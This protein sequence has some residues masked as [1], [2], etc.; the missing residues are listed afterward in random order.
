MSFLDELAFGPGRDWRAWVRALLLLVL[1]IALVA[2]ILYLTVAGDFAFLRA[3]VYTGAPT[4]EYH[5]VGERLAERA[6]RKNGHLRVVVTAGSVENIQR[7]VG[8]SGHCEPGFAFVQDGVPL[9]DDAGLQTLGRLPQPESLLLF[10]RRGRAIASFEDLK[11]ASVGIGPEGSGTGFLMQ[12]LLDNSDLK[13]LG[14]K[15]SNYGLEA[16]AALVQANKLDIAAFVMNEN[17][18]LI[19]NLVEKYDLEIVSP[20]GIDGLTARDRWLH[21]GKIPAGYYDVGRGIPASDKDVAQVDT[22]LIANGCVG[23]AERVAFLKLLSDEF[24]A[25]VRS[26]P[27]PAAR[28]QD[29]APLADEA[30][31][32]FANGQPALPDRY[33]P[34]LVNLMS[35]AYWIYLAMAITVLLNGTEVY[36]RFRLWRI[37][38]NRELMEARLKA[39]VTPPLTHDQIKALPPGAILK[40]P[41]DCAAAQDL[42]NDLE[43]LRARCAAQLQS[44]VTPMGRELYYRYQESMIEEALAALSVLLRRSQGDA[45]EPGPSAP[46]STGAS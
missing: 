42:M 16:Q 34:R 44:Y 4:G 24:P 23:R 43:A 1:I 41:Q 12:H 33:F 22:L 28:S 2:A 5:A 40:S 9:T 6:L 38:A 7:L 20:P 17:A 32:F 27:P 31:E 11:G 35:P 39:L 8:E 30:R 36:S 15:P 13:D 21:I 26:N 37:D 10:A 19:R 46:P 25:F 14:L 45:G 3:S 18:E 29:A